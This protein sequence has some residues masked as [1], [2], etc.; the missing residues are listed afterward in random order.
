MAPDAA[1]RTVDVVRAGVAY[2]CR[3]VH[4]VHAADAADAT[5][6]LA[7][8]ESLGPDSRLRRFG[9]P[10]PRYDRGLRRALTELDR[11][12][13]WLARDRLGSCVGEARVVASRREPCSH[14]AVTVA[15]AVQGRGLGPALARL[16]VAD[17]IRLGLA[18]VV[19]T[20]AADNRPALRL[21]ARHGIELRWDDG[22][23]SGRVRL[24]R[25]PVRAA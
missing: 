6:V 17:A 20:I 5:D 25:G 1:D 2:R 24:R 14:L 7:L 10:V 13:V 18:P 4:A 9:Q 12:P 15:D 3:P 16:A 22:L 23:L 19:V 21:A 8:Y 11:G